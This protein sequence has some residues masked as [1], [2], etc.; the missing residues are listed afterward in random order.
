MPFILSFSKSVQ[1][2]QHFLYILFHVLYLLHVLLFHVQCFKS[3]TCPTISCTTVIDFLHVLW[4]HVQCFRSPTCPLVYVQCFRSP[5]CPPVSC[6][7]FQ[8]SYMSSCVMYNVLDL[9]HVLWFHVREGGKPHSLLPCRPQV[10]YN[11]HTLHKNTLI[12]F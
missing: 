5:T 7:M 3:P 6:I 12:L 4:F 8:I 9:L 11:V 1:Y 10:R 2:L